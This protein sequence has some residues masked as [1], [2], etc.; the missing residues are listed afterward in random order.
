MAPA[1]RDR[2]H[3]Q[4]EAHTPPHVSLAHLRAVARLT[5]DDVRERIAEETGQAPPTRGTLSA[6]E[7]GHRGCSPAMLTALAR[8][9][10]LPDDAIAVDYQPKTRR[11]VTA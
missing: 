10:G 8:A 4:R 6:I 5:L 9:Y 2:Y 7:R 1:N 3:Q 11:Q